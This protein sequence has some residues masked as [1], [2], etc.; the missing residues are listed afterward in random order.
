VLSKNTSSLTI[1]YSQEIK[2]ISIST[3]EGRNL[4]EEYPNAIDYSKTTDYNYEVFSA[5]LSESFEKHR[6][7][8]EELE[9]V[10]GYK[11]NPAPL[12]I[13][14]DF[15]FAC[16]RDYQVVFMLRDLNLTEL[17]KEESNEFQ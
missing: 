7:D 6:S 17:D 14:G 8:W 3:E 13:C 9:A 12:T 5:S 15:G 1:L 10:V 4:S 16:D 11:V 2:A